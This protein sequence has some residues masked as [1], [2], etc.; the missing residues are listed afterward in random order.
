[1]MMTMM[2]SNVEH[3][4]ICNNQHEEG[5][6]QTTAVASN[7]KDNNSDDDNN[8]YKRQQLL[9]QTMTAINLEFT[10]EEWESL[11]RLRES[12]G[13]EMNQVA[14][15]DVIG[16][17]MGGQGASLLWVLLMRERYKYCSTK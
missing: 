7:D 6:P 12:D 5:Q 13:A 2:L 11:K 16:D 1:M 14:M 3:C 10:D 17:R 4:R 15:A 8:D 9:L